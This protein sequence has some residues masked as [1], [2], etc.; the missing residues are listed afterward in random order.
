L[1]KL[2]KLHLFHLYGLEFIQ[3]VCVSLNLDL[4]KFFLRNRN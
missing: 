3:H 2:Y 4:K 1:K